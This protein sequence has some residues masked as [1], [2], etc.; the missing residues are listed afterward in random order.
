MSD[1]NPLV[2]LA[3]SMGEGGLTQAVDETERAGQ[4]QMTRADRLPR[5]IAGLTREQLQGLG[6]V[7]GPQLDDLFD[8]VIFPPGW[9]VTR[10]ESAL[11]SRVLDEKGRER[12]TIMYKAVFYNRDA[13]VTFT[14]RYD[15]GF[16]EV[17]GSH[18]LA[19]VAQNLGKALP[20]APIFATHEPAEAWLDNLHPAWRDRLAYWS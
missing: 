13:Y 7:F 5:A 15:V 3:A 17:E 2:F 19:Y 9:S 8:K 16:A 4:G 20:G 10:A 11:Y 14:R 18:D 1:L 6:F 12:G